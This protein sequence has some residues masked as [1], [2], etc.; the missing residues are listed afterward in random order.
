MISICRLFVQAQ[1]AKCKVKLGV[2][3]RDNDVTSGPTSMQQVLSPSRNGV[4][5]ASKLMIS[6]SIWRASRPELI[7]TTSSTPTLSSYKL[8]SRVRPCAKLKNACFPSPTSL[9]LP[10]RSPSRLY[11]AK[12]GEGRVLIR[13]A[14]LNYKLDAKTRVCLSLSLSL[15]ST[16]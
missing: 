3:F 15:D 12:S 13:S 8:R 5:T 6:L 1:T 16:L 9:H 4:S 2:T 7:E 11:C 14:G 10:Q